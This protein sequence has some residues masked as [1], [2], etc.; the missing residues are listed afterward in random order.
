MAEQELKSVFSFKQ[1]KFGNWTVIIG[2]NGMFRQ[3]PGNW[4]IL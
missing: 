1:R 3:F 4:V 2:K